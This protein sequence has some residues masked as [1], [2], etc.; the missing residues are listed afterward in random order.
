[1]AE[2]D[3][4]VVNLTEQDGTVVTFTADDFTGTVRP[5][6]YLAQIQDTLNR[7]VMTSKFKKIA[8]SNGIDA[9][10][11]DMLLRE[12]EKKADQQAQEDATRQ[13]TNFTGLK[14]QMTCTGYYCNDKGIYREGPYGP[15]RIIP[16]PLLPTKRITNIE[17]K[18]LKMELAF[19]RGREDWEHVVVPREQIASAQKIIALSGRNIAVNSENAKEVVRYI[20]EIE[21]DNYDD[22]EKGYSISR[23]G[24]LP[25]GQFMP[26]TADVSFDGESAEYRKIYDDLTVPKGDEQVWMGIA[27]EARRGDSVPNRI[28]LAASFAA[29]LVKLINS[30]SFLVHFWGDPGC[31]KTVGLMLGASVWGYPELGGFAKTFYCTKTS[32]EIMASFCCNLPVFL[33]D[34]K[35]A[36]SA[37]QKDKKNFDDVIYMLCAGGNKNRATVNADLKYQRKWATCTI[38]NSE[39]PILQE[40][41][42]GGADIRTIE[43]N[44]KDTKFFSSDDRAREISG[45]LKQNYGFVGRK[46]I[47]QL[48]KMS[49][50]DLKKSHDR[51]KKLLPPSDEVDSKLTVAAAVILLA[52]KI[53][54][55]CI[56]KDGRNLQ[57]D[58]IAEFLTRKSES[59]ESAR[60][61]RA[62]LEWVNINKARFDP[63]SDNKGEF[64]GIIENGILYTFG[65]VLKKALDGKSIKPFL[66]WAKKNNKLIFDDDKQRY[67]TQKTLVSG[68]PK[69]WCYAIILED[70]LDFAPEGS[71]VLGKGELPDDRPF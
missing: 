17:T 57:P 68:E 38:S 2:Q 21:N 9:R 30:P 26:Y 28:L 37:S 11:F 32:N 54:T 69:K 12:A 39:A 3:E 8:R 71:K 27:E 48:R 66:F 67:Q 36:E 40:D 23:M 61:Y 44:F 46:Y 6:E 52:D 20:A 59:N 56:F 60:N 42:A 41:S 33:D 10:T 62:L 15:I 64:Y 65:R 22:L 53:A 14:K 35:I 31:G 5:Y 1:M 34:L 19:R 63:S 55:D 51:Y 50:E 49:P 4:V 29:P 45:I 18:E 47:E 24:W 25:D 58:E 16:H 13:V 7:A 70:A 43:V